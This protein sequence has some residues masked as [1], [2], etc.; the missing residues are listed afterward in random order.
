MSQNATMMSQEARFLPMAAQTGQ[1]S[2]PLF[3]TAPARS[4]HPLPT[5]PAPQRLTCP[6]D[7]AVLVRNHNVAGDAPW[8]RLLVRR[9]RTQRCDWRAVAAR[10]GCRGAA[11]AG[12]AAVGAGQGAAVGAC[13][14]VKAGA[15]CV[16][17]GAAGAAAG[18][19]VVVLV[20]V[21]VVVP[22]LPSRRHL[23]TVRLRRDRVR[24]WLLEGPL[25]SRG[26]HAM[27]NRG[28]V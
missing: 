22:V 6:P 21:L 11:A 1:A 17:A 5:P 23:R 7:G 20:V 15:A 19:V 14:A 28:G 26:V 2:Q 3:I 16:A 4:P 8:R 12:A 10:S 25:G 18:V 13:Q 27:H 9:Q 24:W